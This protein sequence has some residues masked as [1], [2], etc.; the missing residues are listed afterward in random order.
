MH[1]QALLTLNFRPSGAY[2]IQEEARKFSFSFYI[3]ASA[4]I[5]EEFIMKSLANIDLEIESHPDWL[6]MLVIAT[7]K[8]STRS[9][10]VRKRN[11]QSTLARVALI[12]HNK[13]R[14]FALFTPRQQYLMRYF[15]R[16]IIENF[17]LFAKV[18]IIIFAFRSSNYRCDR[19]A[20]E[21]VKNQLW[22]QYTHAAE[23]WS[24]QEQQLGKL[25]GQILFLP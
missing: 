22:I 4:G 19:G 3:H 2:L 18:V 8:E 5:T 11:L 7:S 10:F 14:N 17:L 1:F 15:F 21:L 20:E 13:R 24:D 6:P 25:A 16:N 23:A 9:F 12:S